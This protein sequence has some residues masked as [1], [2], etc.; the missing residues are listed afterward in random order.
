MFV[1]THC[2]SS[3]C[4]SSAT[5]LAKVAK[6]TKQKKNNQTTTQPPKVAKLSYLQVIYCKVGF[7]KTLPI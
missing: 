3:F 2:D 6:K 7:L 1:P 4:I 5:T